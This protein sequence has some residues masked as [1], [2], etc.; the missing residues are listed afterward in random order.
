MFEPVELSGRGED[1]RFQ[2]FLTKKMI[3]YSLILDKKNNQY[4]K[5]KKCEFG[6]IVYF[7]IHMKFDSAKVLE[8]E[9]NVN[10]NDH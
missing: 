2:E 4:N 5:Y 9:N 6:N 3:Q 8:W 1:C 7:D 10:T